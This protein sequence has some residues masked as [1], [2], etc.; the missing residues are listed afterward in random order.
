MS[1]G[2]S[3]ALVAAAVGSLSLPAHAQNMPLWVAIGIVSP[4]PMFLLCLI[5]GIV[6]RS[7]RTGL[8]HAA[9]V[10]AWIVLFTL[11][12]YFV[13]NDYVIWTPLALYL[14]H[15]MLLLALIFMHVTKRI[16]R[17]APRA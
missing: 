11:A 10:L 2:R 17:S 1:T 14:L 16:R 5:L 9:F 12:S 8:R 15:G 13:E 3:T 6:A 7:A 4:I